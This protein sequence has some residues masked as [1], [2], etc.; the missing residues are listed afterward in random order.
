MNKEFDCVE[1][2]LQPPP[3][4][5]RPATHTRAEGGQVQAVVRHI[6]TFS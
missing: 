6:L 3:T 4:L 2:A 5:A 1:F